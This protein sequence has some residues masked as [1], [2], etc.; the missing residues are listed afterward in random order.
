M[1]SRPA[2]LVT[3]PRRD[4][5]LRP[6]VWGLDATRNKRRASYVFNHGRSIVTTRLGPEILPLA[7]D[8]GQILAST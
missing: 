7:F 3:R 5:E 2:D 8:G 1:A 4:Y 6:A